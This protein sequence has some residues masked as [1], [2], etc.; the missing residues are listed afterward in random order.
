MSSSVEAHQL[1]VEHGVSRR[2][3]IAPTVKSEKSIEAEHRKD[4]ISSEEKPK[5]KNNI[6]LTFGGLQLA[7]FLAALDR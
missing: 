5:R 1:H 3:S 6:Y 2:V 7:L 4:S